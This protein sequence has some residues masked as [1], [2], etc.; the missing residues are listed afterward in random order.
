MVLNVV[1]PAALDTDD[2]RV[3]I[4]G[5][6]VVVGDEVTGSYDA[7]PPDTIVFPIYQGLPP[8]WSWS[9]FFCNLINSDCLAVGIGRGKEDRGRDET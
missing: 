5:R 9:F 6:S 7:V 1:G 2:L 8:G 4:V 3:R